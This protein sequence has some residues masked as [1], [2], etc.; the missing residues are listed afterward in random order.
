MRRFLR[1]LRSEGGWAFDSG[2]VPIGLWDLNQEFPFIKSL[3][4]APP[5]PGTQV[6]WFWTFVRTIIRPFIVAAKN[7]GV[8][9]NVRVQAN[10]GAGDVNG[11]GVLTI[12]ITTS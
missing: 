3:E 2:V 7:F 5:F 9:A 8:I 4:P 1:W 10:N 11:V 6:G 12:T